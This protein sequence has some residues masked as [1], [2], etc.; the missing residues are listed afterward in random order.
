M[1]VIKN[2]G[3]QVTPASS[4]GLMS[5][6]EVRPAQSVEFSRIF[7]LAAA[8]IQFSLVIERAVLDLVSSN[9]STSCSLDRFEKGQG[10]MPKEVPSARE[11]MV[12][13]GTWQAVHLQKV[14]KGHSNIGTLPQR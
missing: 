14:Y 9:A 11:T 8:M 7:S 2:C 4:A 12:W 5:L 13:S 1:A 6:P 3:I 10:K